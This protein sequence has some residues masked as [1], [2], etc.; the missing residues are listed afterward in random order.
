VCLRLYSEKRMERDFPDETSPEIMR[1]N[2][3]STILTLKGMGIHDPVEFDYMDP[4]E[5]DKIV[6]ALRLLYLYGA[7]DMDGAMTQIGRDMAAF[8]L[9]PALS[10]MLLA[11]IVHKCSS[12]MLTVV[13]M[14]AVDGANVFYRPSMEAE[15]AAATA[16]R[17]R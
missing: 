6:A 5:H 11:S 1:T 9:E 4:P 17:Q 15:K 8:P 3:S 16:A 14:L 7:I 2:L 13:G 12:D 10:R